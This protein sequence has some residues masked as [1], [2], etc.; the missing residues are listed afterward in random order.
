MCLAQG[1]N[2]RDGAGFE[3]PTLRSHENLLYLSRPSVNIHIKIPFEKKGV[4]R[5]IKLQCNQNSFNTYFWVVTHQLRKAALS[6]DAD[7][8]EHTHQQDPFCSDAKDPFPRSQREGLR[9]ALPWHGE[10]RGGGTRWEN[11]F[12]TL[13]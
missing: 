6:V 13:K 10:E 12:L 5:L 8:S 1:H 3:Q 2:R 9:K 11:D 4:K 7:P